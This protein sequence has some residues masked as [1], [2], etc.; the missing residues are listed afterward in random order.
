MK[1]CLVDINVWMALGYTRHQHHAAAAR[2]F[3]QVG[4]GEA[5]FCR[6][7]QF[8][9]LRLLTNPVVMGIDARTDSEAW[10]DYDE[11]ASDFRVSFI[12]EPADCEPVLRKLMG[13]GRASHR[14]W[15]D[16]YLAAIAITGGMRVGSFDRA[17]QSISGRLRTCLAQTDGDRASLAS[18]VAGRLSRRDCDHGGNAGGQLRPGISKHLRPIANLSCAN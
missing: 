9:F 6:F 7:T 15:Q 5:T 4:E 8:G 18:F 13:T 3:E 10:M 2:W 11:L 17:F 12:D 1:S 14:L 16:A